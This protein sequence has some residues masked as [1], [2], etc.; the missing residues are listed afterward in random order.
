MYLREIKVNEASVLA[1]LAFPQQNKH[2]TT[3]RSGFEV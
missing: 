1:V 3:G 2:T